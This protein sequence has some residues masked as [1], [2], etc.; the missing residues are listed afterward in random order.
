MVFVSRLGSQQTSAVAVIDP[1]TTSDDE[2]LKL[3]A[4][5]TRGIRVNLYRYGAME[6]VNLQRQVLTSHVGRLQGMSLNWSMT[7]TT[8]RTA[9]W[10]ELEPFISRTVAKSGIPLVTD[11]FALLK[12]ASMLPPGSGGDPMQQPGYQAVIRL[13]SAGHLWVKLSAPYRVSERGPHYEDLKPLVRAFID[14]NK[15]RVLWGSDWPHTPR[16]KVRTHEEAMTETP[17]LKVNDEA[18][19]RSLRK[20]LSDEEWHLVMVENPRKLFGR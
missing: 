2:I 8:I 7:M 5:G 12:G 17:F 18:W 15:E 3:N 16:M 20:W 1:A 13:I 11:H 10:E 4:A 14:A 19:L 9:S 6:D